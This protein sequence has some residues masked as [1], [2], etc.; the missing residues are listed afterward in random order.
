L[1]RVMLFRMTL[2]Y[3]RLLP[4]DEHLAVPAPMARRS[5][6]RDQLSLAV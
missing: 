1:F 6:G 4:I 2:M 3:G 5:R